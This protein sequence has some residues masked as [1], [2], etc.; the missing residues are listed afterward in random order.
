MYQAELRHGLCSA[1]RRQ[2]ATVC[3][4]KE[5]PLVWSDGPIDEVRNIPSLLHCDR[6]HSRQWFPFVPHAM[7]RVTDDEDP[8]IVGN[9]QIRSDL[10]P[11]ERNLVEPRECSRGKTL[12]YPPPT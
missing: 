12:D 10:D 11:A 8:W 4:N 5:R 1:D 2:H 9:R 7:C 3:V 6:R